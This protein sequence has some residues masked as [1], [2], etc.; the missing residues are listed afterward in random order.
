MMGLGV[1]KLFRASFQ[2]KFAV[3]LLP[4]RPPIKEDDP[5]D[6]CTR[7]YSVKSAYI[8]DLING[9]S[10]VDHSKKRD[11]AWRWPRVKSFIWLVFHE[12][13]L[14]NAQ[15][16]KR[17]LTDCTQFPRCPCVVLSLLELAACYWD[18]SC[19][20][21]VMTGLWKSLMSREKEIQRLIG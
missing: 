17:R 7:S 1:G 12:S 3:W 11:L 13:I 19:S 10:Q 8:Y 20:P 2:F 9:V 6:V 14:T 5:N 4:Y 21:W 16:L 18:I 15:Q